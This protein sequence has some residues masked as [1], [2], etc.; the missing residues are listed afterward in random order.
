MCLGKHIVPTCLFFIDA[1]IL[2]LLISV[3]KM[4]IYKQTSK[5]LSAQC[6]FLDT[7]N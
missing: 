5:E 1:L 7:Y 3:L 2:Q 6:I 4:G